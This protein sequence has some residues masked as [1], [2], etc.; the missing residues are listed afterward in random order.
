[1]S[2]FRGIIGSFDVNSH[3]KVT[4][5]VKNCS[6]DIITNEGDMQV[7]R[8]KSAPCLPRWIRA[9]EGPSR[10]E[11]HQL[12]L[13]GECRPCLFFSR[14]ADGCRKGN[15][16]D[17]CHLCTAAEVKK[18]VNRAKNARRATGSSAA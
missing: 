4:I 7:H 3:E 12:H 13:R 14:K 17:H 8:S 15:G 16:C 6:I 11:L 5:A 2:E 18:R 10:L 1:M 9:G